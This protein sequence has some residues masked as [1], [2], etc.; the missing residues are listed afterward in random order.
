MYTARI[1][2]LIA[3]EVST[4]G[5]VIHVDGKPFELDLVEVA[6][7]HYHIVRNNKSYNIE[8]VAMDSAS[9]TF[10]FK[11]NG[12]HYSVELRDKFDLLLEKMG[13]NGG[14]SGKVNNVKAP[15]PGLIIDLRVR[16]GQ[17]VMAG[18]TLLIL[19]AMKMENVIKAPRDGVIK[20]LR[21]RQGD[22]VEKN[23]VLIEF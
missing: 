10:S 4:A 23:Q 7:G 11:L 19:E 15:M 16:E 2:N 9:K 13:M 22:S 20:T 5:G 18:D 6:D 1:N 12:T 3:H 17:S 21:I 14:A 8:V